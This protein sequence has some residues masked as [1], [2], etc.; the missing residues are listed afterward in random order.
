MPD[1][2]PCPHWCCHAGPH[3]SDQT[4]RVST[5]L[6]AAEGAR[7]SRELADKHRPGKQSAL[8]CSEECVTAGTRHLL[9]L[10]APSRVAAASFAS[11]RDAALQ[12]ADRGAAGPDVTLKR[13]GLRGRAQPQPEAAAR[14]HQ[15][16]V[17][18][19]F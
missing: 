6:A 2:P 11:S 12:K 10:A 15:A 16:R 19:V 14:G 17:I 3:Q 1:D 13:N 8:C 4:R 7:V 5:E 18:A 9:R